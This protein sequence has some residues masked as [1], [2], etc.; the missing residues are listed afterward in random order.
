MTS[1]KLNTSLTASELT[2]H[3]QRTRLNALIIGFPEGGG[4]RGG[5]WCGGHC[6]L[7]ISK[8]LSFPTR[9]GFTF[10]EVPSIWRS[11]AP[12]WLQNFILVRLTV[13][14]HLDFAFWWKLNFNYIF[15]SSRPEFPRFCFKSI[16]TDEEQGKAHYHD[17]S[18]L[19]LNRN[20][21]KFPEYSERLLWCF[22]N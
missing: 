13:S 2:N 4:E 21:L 9:G 16:W 1:T 7:C 10:C 20:V 11:Q 15:S 18:L 12:N 6:K 19:L 22:R 5:G 14:K 17:G 3:F 8:F